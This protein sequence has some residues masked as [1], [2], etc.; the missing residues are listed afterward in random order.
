MWSKNE[1]GHQLGSCQSKE[2]RWGSLRRMTSLL[3]FNSS[4][5]H[6]PLHARLPCPSPS[7][8]HQRGIVRN[9]LGHT[10]GRQSKHD[11]LIDRI[12]NVRE[13]EDSTE[14][15]DSHRT[16]GRQQKWRRLG[17]WEVEEPRVSFGAS[18]CETPVRTKWR[19]GRW[20]QGCGVQA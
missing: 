14:T 17:G 10:L 3:L 4:Q 6:G 7:S 5:P 12:Q 15:P 19:A 20:M 11:L 16:E 2:G 13:R 9:D 1:N 18:A 8:R